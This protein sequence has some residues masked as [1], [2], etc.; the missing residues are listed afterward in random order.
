M[1]AEPATEGD[2]L[3]EPPTKLARTD[4][5]PTIAEARA[6]SPSSSPAGTAETPQL[7]TDDSPPPS[8]LEEA[9]VEKR[10][11]FYVQAADEILE[12]V[13]KHE[14]FLFSEA[15]QAA[16]KRLRGLD[17]QARYLFVRLYLR[18]SSW[19]RLRGISYE[20]DIDDLNAACQAL[21]ERVDF[22]PPR[23]PTPPPA[24]P[25]DVKPVKVEE[26][27]VIDLT[28]DDDDD[29][30]EEP[31]PLVVV[32]EEPDLSSLAMGREQLALEDSEVILG[33][34]SLEELVA[35]GKKMKV[36]PGKGSRREWTQGLLKTSNQSTLSFF[37]SPV[38]STKGKG[39]ENSDVKPLGSFGVG[40]DA[41]GNKLKA[42]NV[43]SS[44]AL[45][46]I[47]SVIQLS[48]AYRSL[49]D[50]LSLVYHRTSYTASSNTT[51][52]T[53]SLLARFGKRRYPDY[54]VSRTFAIFSSRSLLQQ[55]EQ[56][57]EVERQIEEILGESGWTPA[58][59]G[60]GRSRKVEGT[61]RELCK[62]AEREMKMEEDDD[63]KRLLYYRRRF[64]PG[65]PLTRVVYK[66]ASIF[67]K[68]DDHDREVSLLRALLAQTSFRRGKRGAWYDR[69][70]LGMMRYPL[71]DEAKP[72]CKP[73]KKER[74]ARQRKL[75]ALEVCL[76]G[77]EDPY[78]H[79][80]YRSSLQRRIQRIES[81]LDV[82]KAERRVFDAL[83]AKSEHRIMEGERLDEPTIGKKSVWRASDGAE[84]GVEELALEQYEREGWKG[85]HSENGILTTIFTL[86][87]WDIVF[88]PVNGVFETKYQSAPLDLST[89]AFAIVRRPLINDRLAAIRR[90]E[91]AS[92]LEKNDD[93]ERP[94]GTWAVGVNWEKFAKQDLLEIVQCIGGEALATI[95]T[96]FCEEYGH[97]TGGIPDLC[98]W[99]PALSLCKFSEVKGPGDHLSETQKV[100]IDVL[101]GAGVEVEV[102]RVVTS[103]EKDEMDRKER[104]RS[105]GK[106]K[107]RKRGRTVGSEDGEDEDEDE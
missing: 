81:S 62:E 68:L 18:K 51:S 9:T 105:K 35:L 60:G 1:A 48:P 43:V 5:S 99:N 73:K 76:K 12:A 84:C 88:A 103:E 54:E 49:F 53:A 52:F 39:K 55:Y 25:V 42:S 13:L 38:L 79:L 96:M 106:G 2:G 27:G 94:R 101:L 83:L 66:A 20:R 78:T 21:W 75:D 89:D 95:L 87:F 72:D 8:D 36:N 67:A 86:T 30:E 100:W 44:H 90:G 74:L 40:F 14:A 104:E 82:P 59:A 24:P 29:E 97:R 7:D 61:W 80:V 65:W 28:G 22:A 50:R 31:K 77:L 4:E 107:G 16:L 93:R 92:F 11:S 41:K 6:T 98:L 85:F 15:E 19:I 23:P 10:V 45:K 71:G 26:P 70:A 46:T 32:E 3:G 63:E 34:L 47:G 102:C 33:L 56:G 69:L 57:L 91:A 37:A 64:H 17:Y 58:P